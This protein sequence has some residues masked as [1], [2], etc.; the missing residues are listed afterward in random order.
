MI[1]VIIPYRNAAEWLPRCQESC[2][3]GGDLEIIFVDDNSTDG[4]EVSDEFVSLKNEHAP[5]VSGARNTGLDHAHGDWITFLD[6]DDE[7]L[8]GAYD[9]YMQMIR[10]SPNA[11]IIQGS[12]ISYSKAKNRTKV[13]GV[14]PPI[15]YTRDTFIRMRAFCMVWNKLFR[16]KAI[17]GICFKEG[18]QFGEDELF[19]IECIDRCGHIRQAEGQMIRR[20]ITPGSLSK[21]KGSIGLMKQVEVLGKFAY[22][23]KRADMSW[24]VCRIL[25][26]HW[27]SKTFHIEF[28][29][30]K[31]GD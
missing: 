25:S 30:G 17:E 29:R 27:G 9:R 10:Q 3:Q 11:D 1:S 26:E 13:K 15:D 20:N 4:G 5:G 24:A 7:L 23:C 2:R 19:V 12:Y 8:P 28:T 6:A 31:D 18:M 16:R 14:N 21:I 22:N